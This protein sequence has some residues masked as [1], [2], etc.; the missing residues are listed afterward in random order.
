MCSGN[1]LK[2][3]N[4]NI[5][6]GI[7]RNDCARSEELV[8]AIQNQTLPGKLSRTGLAPFGVGNGLEVTFAA[9]LS[10]SNGWQSLLT[11]LIPFLRGL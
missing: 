7:F 1:D 6:V 5:I 4:G 10:A 11:A 8:V 9:A 3:S 2:G